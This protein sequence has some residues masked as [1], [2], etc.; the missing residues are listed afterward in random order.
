MIYLENC[1]VQMDGPGEKNIHLHGN[2]AQGHRPC[3]TER[4]LPLGKNESYEE[5][6]W[7]STLKAAEKFVELVG[8]VEVRLKFTRSEAFAKVVEAPGVKVERRGQNFAIGQY[9]VTPGGIRAACEAQ[10]ITQART[11][12]RNGQTILVEMIVEKRS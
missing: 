11:G 4:I 3:N 7:P 8:G 10:R 6:R 5:G 1:R 2:R 12:K 9:D